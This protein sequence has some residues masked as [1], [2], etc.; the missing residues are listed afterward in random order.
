MSSIMHAIV[1][2]GFAVLLEIHWEMCLTLLML[3]EK[4]PSVNLFGRF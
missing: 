1:R 3:G 4:E 2:E